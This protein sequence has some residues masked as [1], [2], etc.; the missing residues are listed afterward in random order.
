MND[1]CMADRR[2][3]AMAYTLRPEYQD[4]YIATA[5]DFPGRLILLGSEPNLPETYTSPEVAAESVKRWRQE[6]DG[7]IACCGTVQWDGYGWESW[8]NRYLEV[9]G[10]PPDYFHVHIFDRFPYPPVQAFREWMVVHDVVRPVIV[11]EAAAPWDDAQHNAEYMTRLAQFVADGELYA[12]LWYSAPGDYWHLWPDTDLMDW[13][14]TTL[15]PLGEHLLSLQPGGANNPLVTPTPTLEPTAEEE[16][17][18]P[19]R[20]VVWL[21]RLGAP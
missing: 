13:G 21:P 3:L 10:E 6:Y 14:A 2:C 12:V 7:P 16:L 5:N 9:G 11:S 1:Q 18:Q 4:A 19:G 15:T 8:L 20:F 17:G